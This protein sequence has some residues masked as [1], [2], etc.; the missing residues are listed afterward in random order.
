MSGKRFCAFSL[1]CFLLQIFLQGLFP[2]LEGL[3]PQL[4]LLGPIAAG[5]A[6]PTGIG[7]CVAF[8]IGLFFD[9]SQGGIVGP[10]AGG[11]VVVFCLTATVSR[12][13]QIDG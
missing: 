13:L 10:W 3:L 2:S 1:G 11:Y 7:A 5:M 4:T 9:A 6:Y 12:A 8:V